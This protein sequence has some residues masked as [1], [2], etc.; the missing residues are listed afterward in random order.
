MLFFRLFMVVAVSLSLSGCFT[1][2]I[3]GGTTAVA[4]SANDKRS[5]GEQWDDM[6]VASKI[7]ARLVA[8][9]D[10]PSRWVSVEVIHGDVTLTGYLPTQSHIDRAVYIVKSLKGVVAVKNKLL[11]GT[12]RIKEMMSD[13]WITTTIKRRLLNDKLVSGFNIHIETVNGKVYLQGIVPSIVERQRAKDI[14]QQTDGVTAVVDMMQS[15]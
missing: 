5:L 14:A 12:P 2:A 7:D 9:K 4:N 15:D 1:A 13:T 11:V 6:A 10:M 8:E 3:V